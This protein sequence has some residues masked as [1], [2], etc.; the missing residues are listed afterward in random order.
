MIDKKQCVR[1]YTMILIIECLFRFLLLLFFFCVCICF[2]SRIADLQ[3]TNITVP[4]VIKFYSDDND[5]IIK[6]VGRRIQYSKVRD[7]NS[8]GLSQVKNLKPFVFS[9]IL[10]FVW[11]SLL[12]RA[13]I[14]NDNKSLIAISNTGGTSAIIHIGTLHNKMLSSFENGRFQN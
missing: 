1:V 10:L 12:H 11:M 13:F 7:T 9:L 8:T 6:W 4:E 3:S 5:V 14:F 2:R